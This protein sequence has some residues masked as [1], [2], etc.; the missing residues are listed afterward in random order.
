MS[1]MSD[2]N[3]GW[4]VNEKQG[5]EYEQAIKECNSTVSELRTEIRNLKTEIRDL[6]TEIRD[7]KKKRKE[8]LYE[9]DSFESE[10]KKLKAVNERYSKYNLIN[11]YINQKGGKTKS[12]RKNRRKSIK[13]K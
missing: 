7:L 13:R 1:E 2:D 10:N 5:R 3:D 8:L 6:K 11:N 9:F 12:K 4:P